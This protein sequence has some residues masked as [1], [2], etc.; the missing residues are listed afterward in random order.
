MGRGGGGAG[1]EKKNNSNLVIPK[2]RLDVH[3]KVDRETARSGKRKRH[4]S[5]KR[6]RSEVGSGTEAKWEAAPKRGA[7][8]DSEQG[9]NS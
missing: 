5:G 4:R 7:E 3:G 2:A 8:T 1:D 9:I 6:H